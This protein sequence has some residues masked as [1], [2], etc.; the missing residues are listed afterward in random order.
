[1]KLS[2]KA[3][4]EAYLD[5]QSSIG[6]AVGMIDCELGGLGPRTVKQL[7]TRTLK[8]DLLQRLKD[9]LAEK[10]TLGQ[11]NLEECNKLIKDQLGLNYENLFS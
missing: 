3:E 4:A 9:R 5:W 6:D 1:V 11:A 8:P 2:K 10:W 7:L